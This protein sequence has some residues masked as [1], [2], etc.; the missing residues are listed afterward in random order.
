MPGVFEIDL[1]DSGRQEWGVIY[2]TRLYRLP[3]GSTQKVYE[4]PIWCRSCSAFVAGEAIIT[5]KEIQAEIAGLR[6]PD[7]RLSQVLAF[8]GVVAEDKIKEFQR[9]VGWVR[10]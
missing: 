10:D 6:D 4:R 5:L 9:R 8:C 7:E 1:L 2:F 3:D